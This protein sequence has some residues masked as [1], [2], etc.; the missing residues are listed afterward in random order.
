MPSKS[1]KTLEQQHLDWSAQQGRILSD[2]NRAVQH[3]EPSQFAPEELPHYFLR[4]DCAHAAFRSWIAASSP[5]SDRSECSSSSSVLSPNARD[6]GIVG[7]WNRTL[8][9][10]RGGF[11][12]T[13]DATETVFNLQV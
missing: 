12:N 1:A 11:E 10:G 2:N 4:R 7:A 13:T 9:L 3:F 5:G 8:F 6:A